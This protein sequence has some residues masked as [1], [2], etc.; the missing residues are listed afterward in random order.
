MADIHD[1]AKAGD[2]NRIK[3][4]LIEGVNIEEKDSNGFMPLHLAG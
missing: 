3:E 1:A 4:L 2:L